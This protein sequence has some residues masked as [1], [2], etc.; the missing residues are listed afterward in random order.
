[1]V[2]KALI[3]VALLFGVANAL[4]E[5]SNWLRLNYIHAPDC[6]LTWSSCGGAPKHYGKIYGE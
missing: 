2:W 5:R 6:K 1:M 4:S 3:I